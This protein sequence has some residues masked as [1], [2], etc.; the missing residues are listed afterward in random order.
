MTLADV[1]ALTVAMLFASGFVL[2]WASLITMVFD[3][4]FARLLAFGGIGSW[5]GSLA[6]LLLC[7][8]FG[9]WAPTMNGVEQWEP[10]NYWA[11]WF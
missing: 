2:I 3:E 10:K 7:W 1:L 11:E 8:S 9:L 6:L 5:V 4:P